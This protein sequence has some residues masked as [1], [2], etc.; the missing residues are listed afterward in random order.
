MKR[1]LTLDKET[2]TTSHSVRDVARGGRLTVEILTALVTAVVTEVVTEVTH[3]SAEC[4]EFDTCVSCDYNSCGA[5]CGGTCQ[6]SGCVC[7]TL[8]DITCGC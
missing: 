1:K 3:Q 6:E 5:S 2:V 8:Y 4:S 7:P